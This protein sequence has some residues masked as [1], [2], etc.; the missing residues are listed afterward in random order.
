MAK[1]VYVVK[2]IDLEPW[3]S[4]YDGIHKV[5]S[6]EESAKAYVKENE[7]KVFGKEEGFSCGWTVSPYII[8]LALEE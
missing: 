5:F 1:F 6:K 8:K 2:Q 7:G 4:F 3:E